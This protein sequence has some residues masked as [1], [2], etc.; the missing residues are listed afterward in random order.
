MCK[1]PHHLLT[2][3]IREKSVR[4]SAAVPASF[5]PLQLHLSLSLAWRLEA[6]PCLLKG[7]ALQRQ[8]AEAAVACPACVAPGLGMDLQSMQ[9]G[10]NQ[11]PRW[12]EGSMH[13]GVCSC[14][15]QHAQELASMASESSICSLPLPSPGACCCGQALFI[16]PP[17]ALL[18]IASCFTP[19][20]PL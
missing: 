17:R 12:R 11:P 2:D 6:V 9:K 14:V 19:G 20:L 1:I 8:D 16:Q 4:L 7:E 15:S 5:F 18:F 3:T 10:N 13:S